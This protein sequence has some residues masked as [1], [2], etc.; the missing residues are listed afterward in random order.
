MSIPLDDFL[1][2]VEGPS[3]HWDLLEISLQL[4]RAAY[5]DDD[6]KGA[7]RTVD[8]L[9]QSVLNHPEAGGEAFQKI[10]ALNEVIYE[11]FG[12]KGDTEDFYNPDNSYLSRV[13]ERRR[14]IPISLCVLYR[15]LAERIGLHLDSVAMPAHFL[16]RHSMPYRNIFLD[17]FSRGKILLE[18]GCRELLE[19]LSRNSIDFRSEFLQPAS[20]RTVVLRMLANLKQIYRQGGNRRLLIE[21][22]D[23]RIPLLD[24]PSY[25]VL[26]RGLLYFDLD[27]YGEAL[28]D[29]EGFLRTSSNEELKRLIEEKLGE[30]R[31][32]ARTH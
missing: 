1:E 10:N 28:R 20:N 27:Q 30:V 18:D 24:D 22:L 12:L 5:P 13:L 6:L 14:G 9:G 26:E 21:V 3:R 4:C 23:R 31:R 16:L 11:D 17:P 15:E 32:L 7:R 25:E 2:A 29:L 8:D 19:D